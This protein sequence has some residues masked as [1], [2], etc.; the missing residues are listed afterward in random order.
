MTHRFEVDGSSSHLDQIRRYPVLRCHNLLFYLMSIHPVWCHIYSCFQSLLFLSV[1]PRGL[2]LVWPED[3]L[4]SPLGQGVVIFPF[5]ITSLKYS[6]I[7]T[8]FSPLERGQNLYWPFAR[9]NRRKWQ[10]G[11]APPVRLAKL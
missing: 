9:T 7:Q 11:W 1:C 6:N 5:C 2:R 10:S 3:T 8:L 4:V